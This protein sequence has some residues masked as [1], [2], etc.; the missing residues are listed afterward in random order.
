[1]GSLSRPSLFT[2]GLVFFLSGASALVYQVSWQRILALHTGV[3]LYS[4]AVIVAVFMLGLG[5]GSRLGAALSRRVTAGRALVLFAACELGIAAYG[6][7]SCPL[8]YDYLYVHGRCPQ[9]V[10]LDG[11]ID[12][13]C[14]PIVHRLLELANTATEQMLDVDIGLD[15]RA[16]ANI[17]TTRPG[18]P[19]T[20]LVEL[21]DVPY[22]KTTALK[23]MYEYLY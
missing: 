23:R 3:G 11:L 20:S 15:S 19:F 1:M 12:T 7:V 14:R 21:W 4:I 2:L 13:R 8:L 18:N 17:I 5:L 22:V 16:A 6:A 9:E 10:D